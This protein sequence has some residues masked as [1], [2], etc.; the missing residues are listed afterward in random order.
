MTATDVFE[1]ILL[2]VSIFFEGKL[3]GLGEFYMGFSKRCLERN[4]RVLDQRETI[5][6]LGGL[7]EFFCL[8]NN[9]VFL[10]D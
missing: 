7:Q 2:T 6:G 4:P 8:V 5:P 3:S 1:K 9:V 10:G